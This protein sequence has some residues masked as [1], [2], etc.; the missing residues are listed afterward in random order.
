MCDVQK[1][2]GDHVQQHFI[3]VHSG[4]V[5]LKTAF[6]KI[7]DKNLNFYHKAVKNFRFIS[8]GKVARSKKLF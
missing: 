4:L 7:L 3:N 2:M 6:L 1:L 8:I 5:Q